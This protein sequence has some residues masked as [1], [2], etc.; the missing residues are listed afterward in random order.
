MFNQVTRYLVVSYRAGEEDNADYYDICKVVTDYYEAR[1]ECERLA[2]ECS[3]AGGIRF[4]VCPVQ[5]T[6]STTTV[7]EWA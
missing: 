4:G 3:M 2:I 1:T 5:S 6:V 7:L